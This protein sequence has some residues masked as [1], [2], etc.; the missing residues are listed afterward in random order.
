[1]NFSIADVS[2]TTEE[3]VTSQSA[4]PSTV[5]GKVWQKIDTSRHRDALIRGTLITAAL[6]VTTVA[7]LI[8]LSPYYSIPTALLTIGLAKFYGN[9]DGAISVLTDYLPKAIQL[10]RSI[11]KPD[12]QT[13]SS[14]IWQGNGVDVRWAQFTD[15]RLAT[16]IS[17]LL[18]EE[19]ITSAWD[20]G[21]GPDDYTKVLLKNN[22]RCNGLDGNPSTPALSKGR[23]EVQDL[24]L[25]F[26]R[27]VRGC[28]I[29]LEV[30]AKIPEI[31][32]DQ[33]LENISNHAE[34]M[35]IIS[36]PVKE[37]KGP[38]KPNRQNNEYVI[39][40]LGKLG[41]GFDESST[42]TLRDRSHPIF[43][44]FKDTIMVFGKD[45]S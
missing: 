35:I 22:I 13:T 14:G 15:P 11:F 29:S 33:F 37:Q 10:S 12:P 27:E 43:F 39:E 42:Q 4:T 9:K 44:W 25:P 19:N 36:W 6:A 28:V 18:T 30:G 7:S 26:S 45:R 31:H 24:S 16:A 3:V 5:L 2:A 34:D 32:A 40:K 17:E 8:F 21:C 38:N 23:A 41:W 1:M 20:F